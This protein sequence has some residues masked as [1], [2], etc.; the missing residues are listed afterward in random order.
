MSLLLG[1]WGAMPTPRSFR[2]VV[3]GLWVG[4]VGPQTAVAEAEQ[5]PVSAAAVSAPQELFL[6]EPPQVQERLELQLTSGFRWQ[7]D[8]GAPDTAVPLLVELGLTDRLQA[9]V[10]S[11]VESSVGVSA[12]R[13]TGVEVGLLYALQS[14]AP[15][16]VS[17]GLSAGLIGLAG[18]E[19]L[20]WTVEPVL[21]V[22]QS[23]GRLGVNLR[24]AAERER[25]FEG[26]DGE[27]AGAAAL[28][29]FVALSRFYPA[30]EA[31][32]EVSDQ[33]TSV[34]TAAGLAWAPLDG[35]ELGVAM[36]VQLGPGPA[37]VGAIATLTWEMELAGDEP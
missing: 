3:I 28:S 2:G 24:F 22:Q 17:A 18:E 29:C 37:R 7:A 15:V 4:V 34:V 32:V 11:H 5:D 30:V 26:D 19:E 13:M 27:V 36:P 6:G 23:F 16:L 20:A 9:E 33:E 8:R 10:E 14:R 25:A 31:A 21:L 35:V 12:A 1:G